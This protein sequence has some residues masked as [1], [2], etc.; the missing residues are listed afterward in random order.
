MMRRFIINVTTHWCGMN[1]DYAAYAEKESDLWELAAEL[2][3]DNYES[4]N[5]DNDV[6]ESNGYNPEE[7]TD[8]DW[9]RLWE[10]VDRNDY[11]DYYIGE[12]NGSDKDWEMYD[13]VTDKEG[14]CV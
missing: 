5:L 8:G 10:D 3:E 6:A 1:Q 2:A 9:D 13:L 11:F 14:K 4:Y 7:M 12:F